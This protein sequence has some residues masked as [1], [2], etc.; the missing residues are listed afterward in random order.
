MI[1][2]ARLEGERVVGIRKRER[3]E[4]S[5]SASIRLGSL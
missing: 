2:D 3:R 4:S 5:G 1:G